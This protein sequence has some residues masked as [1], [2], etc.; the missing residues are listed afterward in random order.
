M[1]DEELERAACDAV[2]DALSDLDY[3]TTEQGMAVVA[4]AMHGVIECGIN[5][6][7]DIDSI[8]QLIALVWGCYDSSPAMSRAEH[9]A[10]MA[11]NFKNR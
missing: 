7:W 2:S 11:A 4:G 5:H 6:G 3:S 10:E 9:K 8:K 1:T